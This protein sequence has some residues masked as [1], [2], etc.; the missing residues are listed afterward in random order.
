VQPLP[1]VRARMGEARG[2]GENQKA[3]KSS[4]KYK[5]RKAM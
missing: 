1:E 3:E 5:N 4:K 2:E